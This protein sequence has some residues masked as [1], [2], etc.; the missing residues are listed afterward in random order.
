[1]FL[2]FIYISFNKSIWLILIFA[3][4]LLLLTFYYY[5]VTNPPIQKIKKIILSFL[6]LSVLFI[7]M[8]LIFEPILSLVN[9]TTQNPSIAVLI[10][11][12]KSINIGRNIEF[13]Q[14]NSEYKCYIYAC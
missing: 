1:M 10:D 12:S 7:L 2:F 6:R 4:L 3:L 5:K 8:I 11:N 13:Y 14:N 9:I